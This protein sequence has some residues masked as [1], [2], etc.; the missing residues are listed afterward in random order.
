MA[1]T[2][3]PKIKQLCTPQSQPVTPRRLHSNYHLKAYQGI[4]IEGELQYTEGSKTN[5]TERQ[6]S[7]ETSLHY[8]L[9]KSGNQQHLIV[10]K[11]I[12]HFATGLTLHLFS[13]ST[14]AEDGQKKKSLK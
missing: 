10:Q 12:F 8:I 1:G 11:P 4:Q 5:S 13:I 9:G 2:Y 14:S 3:N 6:P 7:E